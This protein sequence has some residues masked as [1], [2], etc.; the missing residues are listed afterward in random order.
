MAPLRSWA[1]R[2]LPFTATVDAQSRLTELTVSIPAAG[3][4]KAS[5]QSA[6]YT[7][8]NLSVPDVSAAKPAP[9]VIYRLL[10]G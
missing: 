5:K 8:G 7:Y 9:A 3:Q 4:H 10:N 6:A 2:A 1:P